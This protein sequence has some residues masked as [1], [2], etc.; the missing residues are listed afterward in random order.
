MESDGVMDGQHS[1]FE[2]VFEM[3][4]KVETAEVE[5]REGGSCRFAAAAAGAKVGAQCSLARSCFNLQIDPNAAGGRAGAG[6]TFCAQPPPA[7]GSD[8]CQ[9]PNHTSR[10]RTTAGTGRHATLH[11]VVHFILKMSECNDCVA[12]SQFL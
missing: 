12:V 3:C 1:T 2:N 8:E 10:I 4:Q 6:G 5:G 9:P 11:H 7:R